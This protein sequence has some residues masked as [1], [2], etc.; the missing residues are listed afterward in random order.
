MFSIFQ[1]KRSTRVNFSQL[2]TDM[3]SHL[4]PGID[5]GASDVMMSDELIKGMLD[6]GYK[7]LITTPHV[8]ADIYPNTPSTIA[9][10]YE[11]LKKKSQ[12][13][14][15]NFPLQTAAEYLLDERL[16]KMLQQSEPL[17]CISDKMVLIEF[18]F[19]APP[20]DYKEKI[21]QLQM[22]GYLPVLAHPERYLYWGGNRLVIDE[23]KTSGCLF[24]VNM[25][26]LIGHYGKPPL[27][28]SNY[29]LKKNYIDFLGTDVHHPRHLEALRS[30][31]QLMPVINQLLDGGGLLNPR[32]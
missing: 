9:A 16:D 22:H 4:L 17:L 1:R 29:L 12:V 8:M 21:F 31:H 27:D 28:I 11:K 18:S 23:L 15:V 26:S 7:K 20:A 14:Q 6:L 19:V 10:A 3:H 30:A 5:D 24:A 13:S 25:L 2:A 32:L